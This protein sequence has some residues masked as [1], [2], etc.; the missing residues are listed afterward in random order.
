MV[1]PWII[2][3]TSWW[4]RWRLKP[5]DSRLF[6]QP[7]IQAQIKEKHQSST[8]LAF[9]KGIH[10]WPMDSP[11]RGTVT[12][13]MFPFDD[14]VMC[15]AHAMLK[16]TL[17]HREN[18]WVRSQQCGYWC[19][20]AKAPGHQYPQHWLNIKFIGPVSWKYYTFVGQH[21]EIK[22]DIEKNDPVV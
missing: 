10:R 17:K 7:F 5:R 22:L 15:L 16:L 13:K 6:T 3:V 18:A 12:R 11:H 8:S 9:V 21:S 20:G 4:A 2:T 14:V 19:P 1:K